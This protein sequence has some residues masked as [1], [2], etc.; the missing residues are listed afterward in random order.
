MT[1]FDF[2][3][4]MEKHVFIKRFVFQ[5]HFSSKSTADTLNCLTRIYT[6]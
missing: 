4:L 1:D 2:K 5:I 3:R 6:C